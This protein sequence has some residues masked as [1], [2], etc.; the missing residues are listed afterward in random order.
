MNPD[1]LDG[2]RQV[3]MKVF[4]NEVFIDPST[5]FSDL[6]VWD[7]LT[8]MTLVAEVEKHFA[9]QFTFEEVIGLMSVGQML[10]L[11]SDKKSA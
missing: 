8:H 10:G 5:Q 6:D 1:Y 2:L 11:I 7:S 9:V 4:G 3:F